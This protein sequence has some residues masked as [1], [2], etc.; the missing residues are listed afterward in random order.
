MGAVLTGSPVV[1]NGLEQSLGAVLFG[2][3]AGAVKSVFFR[4]LDD[5]ASAQFLAFPPHGQELPA[6]AQ[7]G[8]FG[9]QRNPLEAPADQ[10][11]VFLGPAGIVFSGKKKLWGVVVAPSLKCRFDCL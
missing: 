1:A 6:T 10:A 5:F 8:F 9:A 11:P 7:A 3:G 4:T 2:G